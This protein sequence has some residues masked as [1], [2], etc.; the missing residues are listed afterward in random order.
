MGVRVAVIGVGQPFDHVPALA[1]IADA[2]LA[3]LCD[4]DETRLQETG[5]AHGVTALFTDFRAMLE[6]VRPDAVYVLPSVMR[7]VEIAS[8]CLDRG[9]PCFIEKPPGIRAEDT[10]VLARLARQRGVAAMVGFNRRFHPLVTA[11]RAAMA[12]HGRPSSIIAEWWKPLLMQDMGRTF[13][14]PVLDHLL[15]VTTIHSVDTLRFLG[16]EV[17]EILAVAGRWYSPYLDAAHALLRFRDGGVGALLSDY[18]TT[19]VERL[20]VHGEGVLIE[21]QGTGVPYR[22]GRIFEQGGWRSLPP[23]S[24]DRTDPDGFFDE[25]QYFIACVAAGRPV[26]PPAAD[27]D[28][29]VRTMELAEAIAASARSGWERSASPAGGAGPPVESPADGAGPAVGSPARAEGPR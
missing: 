25:D 11:A 3:G 4:I 24:G 22:E 28:D 17:E 16:G 1:R 12:P 18:H 23:A 10:R 20:Q 13:P 8:E 27:L 6:R 21:L 7:T 9:F 5:R 19:K 29:A 15:S 26:G 14:R 2:T